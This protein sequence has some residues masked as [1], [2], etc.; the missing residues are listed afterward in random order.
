MLI[1]EKYEVPDTCPDICFGKREG[2]FFQG[3]LCSR[4]PIFNCRKIKTNDEYADKDGFFCMIEADDF[5]EDW[6]KVWSEWFKGDMK[7]YPELYLQRK[8]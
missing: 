1:V 2:I 8:E 3:C 6:A 4:C 7:E 5:R